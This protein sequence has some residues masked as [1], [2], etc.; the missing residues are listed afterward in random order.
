MF[1]YKKTEEPDF[2]LLNYQRLQ[3]A[4]ETHKTI[5]NVLKSD[6]AKYELQDFHGGGKPL[7]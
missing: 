1:W 6:S 5:M 3:K 7:L 4:Q 2:H